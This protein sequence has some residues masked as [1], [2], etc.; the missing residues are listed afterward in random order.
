VGRARYQATVQGPSGL[1][2]LGDDA[3]L[4]FSEEEDARRVLAVLPKRFGKYGLRLLPT[5]TQLIDFRRPQGGGPSG[6]SQ[7]PRRRT[8]D[9]LGFARY[10]AKSRRGYWVIKHKTAAADR[11]QP[12]ER[13]GEP[14]PTTFGAVA[15]S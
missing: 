13:S 4:G 5:K 12:D 14:E 9:L 10:W 11:H 7:P 6:S 15:D 8:F 1:D 3:V 2:P